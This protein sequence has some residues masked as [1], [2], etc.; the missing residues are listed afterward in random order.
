MRAVNGVVRLISTLILVKYWSL[1][2]LECIQDL[3]ISIRE[4][5]E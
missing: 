5:I 4:L 3:K 1:V 2:Y